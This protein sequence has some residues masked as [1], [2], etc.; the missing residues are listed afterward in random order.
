M[1]N[2]IFFAVPLFG[3]VNY[4]MKIAKRLEIKGHHCYYFSGERYKD[5]VEKKGLCFCAYPERIETM[6]RDKNSTYQT[7][8]MST[9]EG[10]SID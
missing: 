4:G 6:F 9:G 1:S 3:H 5:F 10:K 2:F 7:A 8:T